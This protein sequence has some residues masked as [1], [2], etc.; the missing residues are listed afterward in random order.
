MRILGGSLQGRRFYP[1]ADKW[2][3]RPTTDISKEALYNILMHRFDFEDIDGMLDLFGGT[4]NHSY[5]FASRGC[6]RVVYVDRHGPAVHFV[7]K[8]V[9]DWRIDEVIEVIKMDV[10]RYIEK[11][12]ESFDF[13]FAGPPYPLT[14]IPELPSI[15][16]ES[17]LLRSEGTLVLE[18]NQ[19]HD[20]SHMEQL[21]EV[22][23]YGQTHFSFFR[24]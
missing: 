11:S 8:N 4:G 9:Q 3:T 12:R 14:R 16:L 19:L 20:F 1:P 17:G 18:H 5:E 2:P 6:P 23:N 7:K 22:R 24:H 10:F 21:Q 15:I 13:I